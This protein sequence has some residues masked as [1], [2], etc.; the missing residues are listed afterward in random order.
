M[1]YKNFT[2]VYNGELYNT[3]D[4]RKELIKLGVTFT[5][6]S[7]TEVLFKGLCCMEGKV[8]KKVKWHFCFCRLG[9]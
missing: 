5:G 4:I 1:S 6:H 2:I 8:Y 9:W 7:D 3:E